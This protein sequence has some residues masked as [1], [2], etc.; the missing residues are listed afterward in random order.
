MGRWGDSEVEVLRSHDPAI[1]RSYDINMYAII[2]TGGKQYRV[3]EKDEIMI[4]RL[5]GAVGDKMAFDKVLMI[6][7]TD[8]LKIGRPYVEGAAVEGEILE[9]GREPKILVL[10]KKKRKGYKKQQGHR[11]CFTEVK[12]NKI[13]V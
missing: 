7:D 9:Q 5:K 6:G 2:A 13:S 1:L 4:E 8:G 11:Q 12:I 3:S 10:K